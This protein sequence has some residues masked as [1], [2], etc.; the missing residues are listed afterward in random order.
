MFVEDLLGHERP[1]QMHDTA[2]WYW[3]YIQAAVGKYVVSAAR[4]QIFFLGEG[5][6]RDPMQA[7]P[8]TTTAFVLTGHSL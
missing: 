4:I 2:S 7:S 3:L 6:G 8:A 1:M 5:L